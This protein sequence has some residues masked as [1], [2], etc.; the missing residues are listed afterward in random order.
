[1]KVVY[2]SM[3]S[4]ASS[5]IAWI[6][7]IASPFDSRID[8]PSGKNKFTV[9]AECKSLGKKFVPIKGSRLT[10][11]PSAIRQDV[12]DAHLCSMQISEN[13]L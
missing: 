6:A 5:S 8:D 13:P 9:N 2:A 3:S 7:A 12:K 10:P 4:P 11:A 1:M